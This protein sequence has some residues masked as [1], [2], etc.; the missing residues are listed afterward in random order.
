M[1]ERK[2]L[3]LENASLCQSNDY[4]LKMVEGG[5]FRLLVRLS[6][7]EA[8]ENTKKWRGV[9]QFPSLSHLERAINRWLHLSRTDFLHPLSTRANKRCMAGWQER[10]SSHE[11]AVPVTHK[12]CG[13]NFLKADTAPRCGRQV[14]FRGNWRNL[15]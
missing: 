4:F 6:M 10:T 11:S 1:S 7:D 14:E 3:G 12:G 8:E 15:Y 9:Y 13:P 5:R 2:S